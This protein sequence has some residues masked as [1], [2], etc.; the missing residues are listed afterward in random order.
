MVSALGS[1]H[2]VS[3][4]VSQTYSHSLTSEVPGLDNGCSLQKLSRFEE[5]T[6]TDETRIPHLKKTSLL[7]KPS[8]IS[9]PSAR[10]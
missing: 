10:Q 7:W 4:P 8:N 9:L 3:Y 6:S 5:R 1:T 2:P